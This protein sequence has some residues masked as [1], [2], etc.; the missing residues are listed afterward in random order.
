MVKNDTKTMREP[1][2]GGGQVVSKPGSTIEVRTVNISD[3]QRANI[4]EALQKGKAERSN[5]GF[6]S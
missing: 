4:A 5:F 2:T 1:K 3:K 6:G